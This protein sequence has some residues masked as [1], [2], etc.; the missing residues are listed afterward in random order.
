MNN[1]LVWSNHKLYPRCTWFY[2][3]IF[4]CRWTHSGK[5]ALQSYNTATS[6]MGFSLWM[7]CN[8]C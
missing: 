1:K 6:M 8:K 4:I 2:L 7:S 5:R 3:F